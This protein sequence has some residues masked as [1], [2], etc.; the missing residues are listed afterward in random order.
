MNE[1][2]KIKRALFDVQ[3]RKYLGKLADKC[4]IYAAHVTIL[5]VG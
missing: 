1:D 2:N 5:P 3:L 4:G